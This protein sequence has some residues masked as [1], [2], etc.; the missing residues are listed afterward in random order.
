[1]GRP[2]KITTELAAYIIEVGVR[3][4][5]VLRRCR[6]E[7]HERL[8]DDARMQIAPEQGAFLGL[9]ARLL[10]AR[11]TLEVGVFTGYSSLSVALALPE[12]GVVTACERSDE[13][14]AIARG[15][16]EEAGVEDRIDLRLGPARDT[17]DTL[18]IDGAAG[19]YDLAFIDADK[20]GYDDY[21]ERCLELVRPGGVIALDNTLWDGAVVDE[22]D[23]SDDTRA[24]RAINARIYAD[25]RVEPA[26]TTIG[27]GLTLCMRRP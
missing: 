27:D 1:M 26:L 3:E 18:L 7:T 10:D 4:H 16:W 13:Y 5:P 11:R 15:Y 8:G 21:Y 9:L 2:N 19:R 6:L 24:I 12:G 17:L 25:S 20:V 23:T 14:A 22:D